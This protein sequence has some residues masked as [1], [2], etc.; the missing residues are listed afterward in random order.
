MLKTERN[1]C[2]DQ[3]WPQGSD[4][5]PHRQSLAQPRLLLFDLDY[6][7]H[8]PGY[9]QHLIT[10]WLTHR[11]GGHLDLLVSQTFVER[12]PQIVALADQMPG[13]MS[14]QM[15]NQIPNQA[16]DQ[17]QSQ[18]RFVTLTNHEQ[19]SLIDSADLEQSFQ[20]RVRRAFQEWRILQHYT[21]QL[22]TTHC[23][24]MYLDTVLLRLALSS[25]LPCPF[26]GIYFRPLFHYSQFANYQ[27]VR[28][29]Q[30]W[31][32][33]D[34]VCL[35]RL[36]QSAQ[37]QTL[38]C[39]D[40]LAVEALNQL[41]SQHRAL[42]LPDPVQ[43]TAQPDLDAAALRQTLGISP[44]RKICL[45][46][47]VLTERKGTH[48]LL[49]AIEKLSPALCEQLCFLLIGPIPADQQ[50]WLEARV[51][52]ITTF[53]AVQIVC[54]HEFV[55]DH[56][57]Q[58]YFQLADLVLAPYQRHIGMS[59]IL[60]RAAATGTPVLAADFGLMG[61]VTRRHQLGVTVDATD[62]DAIATALGQIINLPADQIA[63]PTQM[64]QF[65]EQNC[66]D[67]FASQIFQHL[68]PAYLD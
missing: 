11:P 40:P 68:L 24:L 67:R 12:H 53:R 31:Q 26:S 8:H 1:S 42:Y 49:A 20:G 50:Q 57:V 18:I 19:A 33:R 7:G 38:F 56:N 36:L 61:E 14:G 15:P 54:R 5:A 45:L 60:V 23:L 46:F 27:P 62:P 37:L 25:N 21:Q 44:N 39:L 47:G 2:A 17:A 10:Y 52:Q 55:A 43:V 13:Q 65:A 66:A 51:D 28:R 64:Q 32:W 9:L 58:P 48:Q 4:S 29:E 63:N 41:D 34:R 3:N 22:G 16:P 6:R 59:A 30:I 35:A